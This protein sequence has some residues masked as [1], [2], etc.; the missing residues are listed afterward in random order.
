MCQH[1]L[2]LLPHL[3]RA[4]TRRP[5]HGRPAPAPGR[6]AASPR[7]GGWTAGHHDQPH[8]ARRRVHRPARAA[9]VTAR[10]QQFSPDSPV[11]AGS[12]G[13]RKTRDPAGTAPGQV[14][15][16]QRRAPWQSR[17]VEGCRSVQAERGQL[18]G[19][20]DRLINIRAEPGQHQPGRQCIQPGSHSPSIRPVHTPYRALRHPG[21]RRPAAV[22]RQSRRWSARAGMTAYRGLSTLACGIVRRPRRS[23][24]SP[25]MS[26]S[27]A[28]ALACA[29]LRW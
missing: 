28:A 6:G 21:R 19:H 22:G 1:R 4:G 17:N 26:G 10:R 14:G 27:R 15:V 13:S 20:T 12:A 9:V 16:P 8:P 5:R 25:S 24:G 7:R 3:A 2:L 11:L 23:G 18:A 29:A